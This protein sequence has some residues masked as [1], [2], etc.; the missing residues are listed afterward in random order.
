MIN[1]HAKFTIAAAASVFALVVAASPANAAAATV[2]VSSPTIAPGETVIFTTTGT[3]NSVTPGNSLTGCTY[4]DDQPFGALYTS[5]SDGDTP[6][7]YD[8]TFV[9]PGPFTEATSMTVVIFPS[10]TS[11]CPATLAETV[12]SRVAFA[13][14]TVIRPSAPSPEAETLPSTGMNLAMSLSMSG[15]LLLAGL[16]AVTMR[17]RSTQR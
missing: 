12:G 3:Y 7:V 15:L 11:S 2:V 8:T 13:P 10:G 1:F 17:R 14:L 6:V 4:I 9:A 16:A 5:T